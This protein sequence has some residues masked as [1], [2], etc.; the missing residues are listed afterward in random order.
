MEK[1]QQHK[2]ILSVTELT[3]LNDQLPHND[4]L[5]AINNLI[6]R[7]YSNQCFGVCVREQ[8]VA[9]AASIISN[10][11]YGLEV[12]SVAGFP[13]GSQFTTTQKI[14]LISKAFEDKASEV[15]IVINLD[16]IKNGNFDAQ[17]QE[18]STIHKHIG[19]KGLKIIFENSL[20][21]LEEKKRTYAMA[22][23]IFEND[24]ELQS[25]K[26]LRFFKTGTGYHGSAIVQDIELMS[27]FTN[28]HTIGIKAAGGIKTFEQALTFFNAFLSASS[29]T[30]LFRIGSSSIV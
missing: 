26:G 12:I 20:L 6:Q 24:Q 21:T 29:N 25:N 1:N 17:Y 4:Q 10:N 5:T 22:A 14:D 28:N 9:M 11:N 13:E 27:Q 16:W 19:N 2:D 3:F 23:E 8:W 15:D 18:W 7:A 30:K